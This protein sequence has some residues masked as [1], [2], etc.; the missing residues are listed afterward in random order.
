M[1]SLFDVEMGK[2]AGFRMPLDM[3]VG[4]VDE[5]G[6]LISPWGDRRPF[7]RRSKQCCDGDDGLA[8][9]PANGQRSKPGAMRK[10]LLGGTL[11]ALGC[12]MGATGERANL[13]LIAGKRIGRAIWPYTED[14]DW[15]ASCKLRSDGE[16]EPEKEEF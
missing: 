15:S 9:Q 3:L 2:Q 6:D 7:D 10:L 5:G 12:S 1:T 16:S 8:F 13:P 4:K 14:T 11:R